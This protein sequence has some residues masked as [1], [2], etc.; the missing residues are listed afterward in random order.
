M[1]D[2][3]TP[4]SHGRGNDVKYTFM[5][6]KAIRGREGVAKT[7]W[8]NQGWELVDQTQGT[9]RSELN[10]R[11]LKPKG[12]GAYLVQGYVAFRGLAPRTQKT[13]R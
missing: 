1:T 4:T 11:K 8:Q 2:E 6:V 9:L 7:K 13:V 10:F 3:P 12:V 5:T